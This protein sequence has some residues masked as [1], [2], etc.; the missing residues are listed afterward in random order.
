[1]KLVNELFG[2]R[3]QSSEDKT[4]ASRLITAETEIGSPLHLVQTRVKI[5]RFTGGSYPTALFNEQPVW[6]KQ[7][8]TI[9]VKL[10]IQQPTRVQIGLVLLLLKD[11]W[12]GDLPLGGESSVGRGRLQGRQATLTLKGREKKTWVL[13]QRAD[14][15]LVFDGKGRPEEL[16]GYVTA[17][18]EYK[19][20]EDA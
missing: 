9:T 11:L 7:D 13:T 14:G 2:S 18:H 3:I 12:T 10:T 8:T 15:G 17:F 16:E 1:M 4:T 19:G 20:G 6:G 5:D